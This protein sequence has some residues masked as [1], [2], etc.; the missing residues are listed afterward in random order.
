MS[1]VSKQAIP[2]ESPW[3]DALSDDLPISPLMRRW[4]S[5]QGSLTKLLV[6]TCEASAFSV[7]VL[8]QSWQPA[9]ASET[10]L[11][12]LKKTDKAFI[13]QVKL[14]CA[15]QYRVYARSVIPAQSLDGDARHLSKL[16][17]KPLGAVLFADQNTRRVKMQFARLQ[18]DHALH[19]LA[20]AH[21]PDADLQQ[22]VLWARR[23]LFSYA[24]HP[25]I[26][27][28]IFMPVMET[29]EL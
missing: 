15:Q 19:A 7:D 27:N 9:L 12:N 24:E 21:Q 6:D 4:L 16:Q 11:L 8:E 29:I 23:T 10:S 1:L 5:D 17:N 3:W 25:L 18:A 26:V 28:E 2:T 22:A 13:R 20:I 14:M